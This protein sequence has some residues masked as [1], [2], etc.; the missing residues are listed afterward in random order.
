[1]IDE[2]PGFPLK[3]SFFTLHNGATLIIFLNVYTLQIS[4]PFMVFFKG[5]LISESVSLWFHLQKRCK[6]LSLI[7]LYGTLF[8]DGTKV[9]NFLTLSNL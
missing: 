7:S 2:M 3:T 9:E 1:M 6:I 5:D 8:G 4:L